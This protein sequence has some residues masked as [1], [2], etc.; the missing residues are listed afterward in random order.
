MESRM[1]FAHKSV[2]AVKARGQRFV[3]W[4]TS[5]R[6]LG[7]RITPN[8]TKTYVFTYRFDGKPRMMTLGSTSALTLEQAIADYSAALSKVASARH[9]QFKGETPSAELDPAAEKRSKRA[10][11]KTMENLHSKAGERA[12]AKNAGRIRTHHEGVRFA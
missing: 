1:R 10:E 11:R 7:L 2:E 4:D 3:V 8:R 5:N 9:L 12:T 6:G